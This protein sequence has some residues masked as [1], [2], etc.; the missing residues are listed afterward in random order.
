M[1]KLA[2]VLLASLFLTTVTVSADESDYK[3]ENARLSGN[4]YSSTMKNLDGISAIE[5]KSTASSNYYYTTRII[6]KTDGDTEFKLS[7]Y[8]SKNQRHVSGPVWTSVRHY[9]QGQVL[10]GSNSFGAGFDA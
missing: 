4:W 10:T 1:K 9:M 5:S 7:G 8:L 6:D 2:I 3:N